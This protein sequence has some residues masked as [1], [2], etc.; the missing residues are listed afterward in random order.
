MSQFPMKTK[1]VTAL[2][3]ATAASPAF[4]IDNG[5]YGNFALGYIKN[6]GNTDSSAGTAK[7]ELDYTYMPWSNSLTFDAASGRTDGVTNTE[8]YDGGDKLK[9][10]FD[11]VD[12]AFGNATY[13]NDRFAG[14][15]QDIVESVGYGR[16]ILMTEHQQLDAEVGAG[17]SEEK[18][19]GENDYNTQFVGTVGGK[20][21]YKF[22]PTAQFSQTLRAEIGTDNTFLDP[23]TELKVS[24]VSHLALL[25]D[26]EVRYNTT[27]PAGVHK[28]DTITT[29]NIGY[30]FGKKPI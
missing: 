11:E 10:N 4:A 21:V 29:I 12:Y 22:S 23:V 20:Y 25:I 28:E 13:L 17:A 24:I 14:I 6:T 1:I 18:K 8:R 9:F 15:Q 26:Y 7:G 27:V 3:C 19:L 5:W 16:R 2:L 30:T